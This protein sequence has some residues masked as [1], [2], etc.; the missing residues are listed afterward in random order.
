MYRKENT[1]KRTISRWVLAATSCIIL[2]GCGQGTTAPQSSAPTAAPANPTLVAGQRAEGQP[3]AA[4]AATAAPAGTDATATAAPAPLSQ[5]KWSIPHDKDILSTPRVANGMVYL[6]D[7]KGNVFALD[8]ITSDQRWT[9]EAEG[10]MDRKELVVAND[11]IYFACGKS[12]L[13]ALD[14]QTGQERWKVQLD[15]LNEFHPTVVG[16]LVLASGGA[17]LYG[18]DAATGA[19]KWTFELEGGDFIT[20]DVAQHGDY[21]TALP[22]PVADNTVFFG[23][24]SS[25]YAVDLT[26]GNKKW[27]TSFDT[28]LSFAPTVAEGM[29]YVGAQGKSQAGA[30]GGIVPGKSAIHA[31]DAQ[32]G[33]ERWTAETETRQTPIVAAGVVY[34]ATGQDGLFALNAQN[35]KELWHTRAESEVRPVLNGNMAYAGHDFGMVSVDVASGKKVWKFTPQDSSEQLLTRPLVGTDAIYF[36]SSLGLDLL[37]FDPQT[38]Q[39]I[40]AFHAKGVVRVPALDED[41]VYFVA[42]DRSNKVTIYAVQ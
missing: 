4:A 31:L 35:G 33:E 7:V 13:Y 32:T 36:K 22:L 26:T 17:Q 15:D 6:A 3:A 40:G 18:V 42:T 21:S 9:Y 27:S 8:A 2:I 10:N 14:A 24:A 19:L 20:A 16:D 25:V 38:G 11:T 12:Y 30:Q 29:V 28:R 39:E 5:V 1:M 37:A 41:T 23:G 34:L